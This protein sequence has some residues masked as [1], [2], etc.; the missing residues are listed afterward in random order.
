MGALMAGSWC[1]WGA[2]LNYF[3]WKR[4]CPA[5]ALASFV[6]YNLGLNLIRYLHAKRPDEEEIEVEYDKT[7]RRILYT[8]FNCNPSYVLKSHYAPELIVGRWASK[9]PI[10]PFVYG[11]EYLIISDL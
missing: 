3:D 5:A 7:A 10:Y 9:K 4:A 6:I 1:W 8:W 2:R 11:K